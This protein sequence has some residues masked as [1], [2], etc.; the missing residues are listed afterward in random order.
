MVQI[1]YSFLSGRSLKFHPYLIAGGGFVF[2]RFNP[3]IIRSLDPFYDRYFTD[4][5]ETDFTGIFG[6]GVDLAINE[7]FGFNLS[8]KYCP[9]KFSN[10]LAGLKDY[11]GISIVLGFN[12]HLFKK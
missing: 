8:A 6:G 5:T 11:S 2:G 1:K 10:A 9:I 7:M 12:Y 3:E 4:K